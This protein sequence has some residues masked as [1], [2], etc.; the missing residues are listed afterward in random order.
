M[1]L[2]MAEICRSPPGMYD[3]PKKIWDEMDEVPINWCRILAIN[4]SGGHTWMGLGWF[5]MIKVPS[6]GCST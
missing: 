1:I 4:S 2:L 6:K 3:T 5:G